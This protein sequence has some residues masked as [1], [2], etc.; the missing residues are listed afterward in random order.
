MRCVAFTAA[1]LV[2]AAC[3]ERGETAGANCRRY[4]PVEAKRTFDGRVGQIR[5]RNTT[6]GAV[7]VRV[8]HPDGD[9]SVEQEWTVPP[10]AAADLGGGFGNDWGI[11]VDNSCVQTVGRASAWD[12]STFAL[13]WTGAAL[14][15]DS[16]HSAPAP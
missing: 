5:V 13:V 6:A 2:V 16:A 3:A 14:A 10:R 15:P 1:I 7:V 4:R 12:H 9:G 8:Y 11:Q